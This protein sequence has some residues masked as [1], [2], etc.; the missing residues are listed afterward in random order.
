MPM[1]AP[2]ITSV[3]RHIRRV[4]G[5]SVDEQPTD[6][7]LLEDFAATRDQ[8]AFA[9]LVTRHGPMV[10]SVCR[11]VLGD[12]HAA[13]DAFQATFLILARKAGAI[14]RSECVAGWLCQVARRVALRSRARSKRSS[15][16]P[17]TSCAAPQANVQKG[18]D[19]MSSAEPWLDLSLRELRS[20]VQQEVGR[21][22]ERY[23]TPVV[24]C[25]LE[26]K[27]QDEAAR[28]LGVSGGAVKGRLERGRRLLRSRLDKRGLALPAAL[29]ATAL[30]KA[31]DVVSEPLMTSVVRM[32][33][34]GVAG[35]SAEVLELAREVTIPMANRLKV[36]TA[37]LLLA[38]GVAGGVGIPALAAR[39][40][41][42][43][44]DKAAPA[45]KP[46]PQQPPAA[47]AEELHYS[48]VVVDQDNGKPI[49]G[50]T[51]IV[52]RSLLQ[53]P[54][55]TEPNRI[56]EES[57][58][59]TD[60][61][62]RY[63]F[64]IPPEQSGKRYLYIEIDAEHP[65][66]AWKKGFGYA[67]S[68]IRKNEKIGGRPF[69]EKIELRPA[70]PVTGIVQTPDGKPAAGVK[71]QAYSAPEHDKSSGF[72]YGS[73]ADTKTDAEGR[74]R[75]PI[76]TKGFAV[77]WL[78]PKDYA[79]STH[80]LKENKRGDMGAFILRPGIRLRGKVVDAN[81]KPVA[82]VIINAES[83]ERNEA[84]TEPV[85]DQIDRSAT[86]NDK[87]EFAMNPL[88]PGKYKV[89]PGDW[90]RDGSLDR[91]ERASKRP[92]PGV[93][94]GTVVKLTDGEETESVEVRA[95]PHV[96]VE[97]QYLDSKGKPTRGHSGFIHGSLDK[98]SWFNEAKADKDG[99]ITALV[100]HGLETAQLQVMTNEHGSLRWRKAKD[101]PLQHAREIPL[102]T[103]TDDV[104]GIEIIRYNA[105]ILLVKVTAKDGSKPKDVGVTAEYSVA[106]SDGKM[107]LAGGRRSDL[108][109]EK[110]ED[111]RFRSEQMLPDDEV[112][113]TAHAEGYNAEPVKLKLPEGETKEIEITLEKQ[114]GAKDKAD[115][116]PPA[117]A[118]PESKP[119]KLHYD[120]KVTDKD[121]GKPIAGA[122][123]TI[124]RSLLE[125]RDEKEF[126]RILETTK[127]TTDAEGK[128]AFDVAPDHAAKRSC[129]IQVK[130]EH[131]DYEMH[132]G[133]YSLA[134]IRKN[135]KLGGRPFFDN[136]PLKH[137]MPVTGVIQSLDGKPAAGVK[138]MAI[139]EPKENERFLHH[140]YAEAESDVAGRFRVPVTTPAEYALICFLPKDH[141]PMVQY[142]KDDKRGDIGTIF[143]R[144]GVRVHGKV[145]DAK[146]KPLAGVY[147]NAEPDRE[148]VDLAVSSY[149]GRT[150]V[151]GADGTFAFAP[152]L[153]G[154][155]EMM[156]AEFGHGGSDWGDFQ[157]RHLPGVFVRSKLT[158]TENEEPSPVEIR[159]V[160]TV[161]VEAQYVNGKGEPSR[162]F[163][164]DISGDLDK[165]FWTGQSK[166][167]KD[168]KLTA[169]VPHGLDKATLHIITNEHGALRWRKSKDAPLQN[170]FRIPL[171]TLT[172]DFRGIE[173]VHYKAPILLV[174]VTG[175]DTPPGELRLKA[176][177]GPGRGHYPSD[178]GIR[179]DHSDVSFEKQEDGRYRSSQLLPDEETMVTV[180]AKGYTCAPVKV[181]LAE[182]ATKEIE[183]A[184][185]KSAAKEDDRKKGN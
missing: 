157:R 41:D 112:T 154:K 169:E 42:R 149:L 31:A 93:F 138:V 140:S 63:S 59:T 84:I 20:A 64:T 90:A 120:C 91:K 151:S 66:Y 18:A 128:Y 70:T 73:F 130:I 96:V 2:A 110:Q 25:H 133:G 81:G 50:A 23:R 156:A 48:G 124:Y 144:P 146:G 86:T 54:E 164:C 79:P 85:A 165:Q 21:L 125:D 61:N 49:A 30:A 62:G 185:E 148:S 28:L 106:S 34:G 178:L 71:V 150:A 177:Y 88:P 147:V 94:L 12:V 58:H 16:N 108:S 5:S 180:E 127:H 161:V 121:S 143:L 102:G 123:V 105:P 152:L 6:R 1:T 182:G 175:K 117:A 7:R 27:S 153:P 67:L 75:L 113:V 89:S 33:I 15:P 8:A 11:G 114:T 101:Q 39:D 98:V 163:D 80:V 4:S 155:C 129:Y 174:K 36:A 179:P 167:G 184:L 115:P 9:A 24:L 176:V 53:D 69:F 43:P 97:A 159:A 141:A 32:A 118:K 160:P 35:V 171:G 109:F 3:L 76:I 40:G 131:P 46:Q 100:P 95:V 137:G 145:L 170:T 104:R 60:A 111:G 74:F 55:E 82:G 183:I 38:L 135:E 83:Q 166:T 142:L 72:E 17:L 45:A 57:R 122:V 132:N 37:L 181:T 52:R 10:L 77:V 99:K 26:G 126:N 19:A 78:L 162:G 13:E 158:F 47:V 68:M 22:P 136:I 116:P 134:M 119:E 29:L 87:G 107:I 56:L 51:V 44:A 172:D 173:I 168:G 103:L 92:P 65:D 139:S 14:R